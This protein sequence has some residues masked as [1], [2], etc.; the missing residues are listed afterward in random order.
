MFDCPEQK[1]TSPGST[2]VATTG[3]PVEPITLMVMLPLFVLDSEY[4]CANV[5]G[6]STASSMQCEAI[7]S[8]DNIFKTSTYDRHKRVL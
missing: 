7:R 3:G 2:F 8:R 6:H 1:N 4:T 5:S